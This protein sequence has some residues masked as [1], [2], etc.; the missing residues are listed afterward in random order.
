MWMF[1]GERAEVPAAGTNKKLCI[2]G[3]LNY[4]TWQV[5]YMV[6]PKK[7][8]TQFGEFLGQLLEAKRDRRV[9]LALDNASYHTTAGILDLMSFLSWKS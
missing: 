3:A 4:S 2:Y 9:V 1:R 7:N 5:Y 6:H 8:S